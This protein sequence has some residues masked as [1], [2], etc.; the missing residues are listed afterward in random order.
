[1][2]LLFPVALLLACVGIY[3][4]TNRETMVLDAKTRA[5]LGG[6]YAALS[7]GVT[8]YRLE[9]PER[10][11]PVVLL[12]GGTIPMLT[13]DALAPDLARTGFRV[14]RYDMYG[15]KRY[16][17]QLKEL[18]DNLQWKE[19]VDVVGY[20]FGGAIAAAFTAQYPGRVRRP[21]LIS[22]LAR[23]YKRPRVFL[24]PV[25]GEFLGR[26]FGAKVIERRAGGLH[27]RIHDPGVAETR[28]N[29]A[30][31]NGR[32]RSHIADDRHGPASSAEH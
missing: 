31:G 1:M 6:T 24:V 4:A 15:R 16:V 12:H 19:P 25:L 23:D 3:V 9:G 17:G 8:H 32:P 2:L 11:K 13:G 26:V 20:S 21:V 29:A 28:H 14:L 5:K 30:M 7:D 27:K 18:L 22:P 10:G